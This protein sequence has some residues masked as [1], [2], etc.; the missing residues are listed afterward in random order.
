MALLERIIKV[1]SNEE[2]VILDP[3]CGCG[4]AVDAAQRLGRRWIGIDVTFI[5]IDVIENR[6]RRAYGDSISNT[7][8]ILGIPRDMGGARALFGR[9]PFDFERWAVS[10]IDATPNEKQVGD[11]GVDGV[12]RFQIDRR[13]IGRVLVSV[14]GGRNVSPQFARDLLGTVIGRKAEMGVLVTMA[15]P[16]AGVRDV[17]DHGGTYV[18]PASNQVLPRVQVITIKQLLSGEHP[19]L[20]PLLPP[21]VRASASRRNLA[22]Q[23]SSRRLINSY[24]PGRTDSD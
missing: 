4:T 12:A 24:E 6:L 13:T 14:K 2:G 3:F 19:K 1:S 23:H 22:T 15:E 10:L 16:T 7:Y 8:D 20:P 17:M 21:Y 5:A 18:S 9:S 11:K